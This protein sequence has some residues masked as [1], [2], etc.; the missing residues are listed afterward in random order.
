MATLRTFLKN[1]TTNTICIDLIIGHIGIQSLSII[2]LFIKLYIKTEV[3][4]MTSKWRR[5]Q[6]IIIFVCL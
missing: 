6:N 4:N 5:W 3:R 1:I 2:R